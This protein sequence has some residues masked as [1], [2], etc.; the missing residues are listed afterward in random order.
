LRRVSDIFAHYR[1]HAA[2]KTSVSSNQFYEEAKVVFHRLNTS[3]DAPE[4]FL[5]PEASARAKPS[6]IEYSLG[7]SFDRE[8]YLGCFAE[9][10]VRTFRREDPAQARTWLKR[11][12]AY[13]PWVTFWR[14]KMALRLLF[15]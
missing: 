9:R 7:P 12:W 5:F 6:L 14:T 3:L 13:K 1:H 10:M 15:R 8:R 11:T 2:S 4:V